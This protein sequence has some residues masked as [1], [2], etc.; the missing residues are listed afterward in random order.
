MSLQIDVDVLEWFKDSASLLGLADD[1][2]R[3]FAMIDP[4]AGPS[5]GAVTITE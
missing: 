4:G 1:L 3:V 5:C 2:L